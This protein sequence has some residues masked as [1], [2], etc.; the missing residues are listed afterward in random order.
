[1]NVQVCD[2]SHNDVAQLSGCNHIHVVNQCGQ[3]RCAADR[4]DHHRLTA[5][6]DRDLVLRQ[7]V[8]RKPCG[9]VNFLRDDHLAGE[10]LRHVL[11]PRRDIDRVAERGEDHVVAVSNVADNHLAAVDA[12][13]EADRFAQVVAQELI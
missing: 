4:A 12:D 11:Q 10:A 7:G 5:P 8:G 9:S 2:R 1:M 13:A 6:A 3:R